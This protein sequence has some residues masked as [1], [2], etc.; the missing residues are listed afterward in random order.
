MQRARSRVPLPYAILGLLLAAW[1]S[2]GVWICLSAPFGSG[3][4]ESI[5][6]VA[7]AAATNRWATSAD[8]EAFG[9]SD[10][11]YPPLYFLLFAPFYGNRPAFTAEFPSMSGNIALRWAGSA[12]LVATEDLARVQ[13]E[14]LLLYRNAKLLSLL[15]GLG[16]VACLVASVRVLFEGECRPWLVLGAAGPLLLLPQFL[17]YHTLV[18]NDCLV[19]L[20]CALALASFIVAARRCGEGECAALS[21]WGMLCAGWVG[22][23]LLTKQSAIVVAPLLPALAWLRWRCRRNLAPRRRLLDAA[24]HFFVLATVTVA[25]GGWWVLRSALAGDPAGLNDQRLAHDWAFRA[26]QLGPGQFLSLL[27][28]V[29]RTFI[30]LFAGSYYGIPDRIYAAYLVIAAG[31]ATA[32][33]VSILRRRGTALAPGTPT[34]IARGVYPVLAAA[35]VFNLLLILVYNTRVLAPHGRLLF[36]TLVASGALLAVSLRVISGGRRRRLAPLVCTL[37]LLLGGLFSWVFTQRLAP[38]VVQP[39]ENLVPLGVIADGVTKPL[40]P[41]WGGTVEQPMLLPAGRLAGFRIWIGRRSSLPQ[42]GAVLHARLR[43]TSASGTAEHALK[44]TSIGENGSPDRWTDVELTAPLDLPGMTPALL[45]LRADKPWFRTPGTD[46]AYELTTLEH[47]PRLQPLLADG[48]PSGLGL[49]VT[50]VYR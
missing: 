45:V 39:A 34:I 27:N 36:P 41:I 1:I 6:S 44:P 11:Y 33:A 29:G 26:A 12:R 46:F 16:V 48:R 30:A 22:L 40:G 4:D 24:G 25:T 2:L 7:F 10:F 43:A 32:L 47:S 50:A 42:F 49:A 17:Y 19:N 8:A 9:I 38:A 31:V 23:G 13:P 5:R 21:R 37:L 35:V 15:F 20:L 18:N 3:T 14:L 28:D